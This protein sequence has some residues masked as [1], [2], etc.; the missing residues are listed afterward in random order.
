MALL[1]NACRFRTN[2]D[3][4]GVEK[5]AVTLPDSAYLEQTYKQ[6]PC[7]DDDEGLPCCFQFLHL[8]FVVLCLLGL[9]PP[10]SLGYIK[11][12]RRSCAALIVA[13]GIRELD[14]SLN[15]LPKEYVVPSLKAVMCP[16]HV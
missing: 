12:W 6:L 2:S 14:L 9:L 13:Q 7:L 3:I 4:A 10:F 15:V 1:L 16:M 5:L 8:C 11:G